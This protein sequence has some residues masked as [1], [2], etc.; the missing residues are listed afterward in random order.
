MAPY[1]FI[2]HLYCFIESLSSSPVSCRRQLGTGFLSRTCCAFCSLLIRREIWLLRMSSMNILLR[3]CVIPLAGDYSA[4]QTSAG[5]FWITN[6]IIFAIQFLA[7]WF[8]KFRRNKFFLPS[9]IRVLKLLW[10]SPTRLLPQASHLCCS[11]LARL[12]FQYNWSMKVINQRSFFVLMRAWV[13]KH[14]F[15]VPVH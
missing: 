14:L 6:S 7:C 3:R 5:I 8:A 15:L 11:F 2:L 1:L 13:L 12:T 4:K 9:Y 10:I